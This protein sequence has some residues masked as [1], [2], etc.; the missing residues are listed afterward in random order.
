MASI[1]NLMMQFR[2]MECVPAV[3][4][5]KCWPAVG[6]SC[7]ITFYKNLVYENKIWLDLS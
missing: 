3:H 7:K 4:N 5:A 2:I 6:G 1:A